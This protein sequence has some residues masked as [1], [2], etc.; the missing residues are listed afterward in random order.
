MAAAGREDPVTAAAAR[1][2]EARR[3]AVAE[4]ERIRAELEAEAARTRDAMEVQVCPLHPLTKRFTISGSASGYMSV[5]YW[6]QA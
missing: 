6:H 4:F 2:A 1:V 3:A 5:S